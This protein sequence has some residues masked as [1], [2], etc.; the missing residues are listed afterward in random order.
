MATIDR[1][2]N[3]PLRARF[4]DVYASYSKLRDNVGD[5]QRQLA[6]LEVTAKSADGMVT[7]VVGARGQ[8]VRLKLHE[9][10]YAQHR[11]DRLA[12]L[13]TETVGRAEVA[14]GQAVQQL[15]ARV[16][17]EETGVAELLR[18]QDFGAVL[19]RH[20]QTMGYEQAERDDAQR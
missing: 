4:D 8:L 17:P 12:T 11:P 14:A 9:R 6:G 20:D 16:V 10:A 18:S 3:A 15:V 13:I 19:R 2:A 1:D 7:V 5:L